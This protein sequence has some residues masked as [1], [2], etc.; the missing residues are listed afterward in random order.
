M[1]ECP[2]VSSLND[3]TLIIS[4]SPK[5]LLLGKQTPR[6]CG[7]TIGY[8]VLWGQGPEEDWL[9]DSHAHCLFPE[10]PELNTQ[11]LS[12]VSPTSHFLPFTSVPF[13][14][15]SAPWGWVS[16]TSHFKSTTT[17]LQLACPSPLCSV[18]CQLLP[19][20]QNES[21]G[22]CPTTFDCSSLSSGSSPGF[23]V[24]PLRS[25]EPG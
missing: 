6:V 4:R 1:H 18:R 16:A 3:L 15:C 9:V 13:S 10:V 22:L 21:S 23:L 20:V 12:S 19:K 14:P 8:D 11:L 25:S 2:E 24:N 7:P 17:A 5:P